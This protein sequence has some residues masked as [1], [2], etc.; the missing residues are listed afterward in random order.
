MARHPEQG[1]RLLNAGIRRKL[2]LNLLMREATKPPELQV[3]PAKLEGVFLALEA[4]LSCEKWN[5][6]AANEWAR[7]GNYMWRYARWFKCA[8]GSD[9]KGCVCPMAAERGVTSLLI[10]RYN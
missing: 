4:F 8:A 6:D 1:A 10:L 2:F 7:I 3:D 9:F 5:Q